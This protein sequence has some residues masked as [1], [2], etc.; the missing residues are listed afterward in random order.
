MVICE[1]LVEDDIFVGVLGLAGL[2]ATA[3]LTSELYAEDPIELMARN[4]NVYIL[5]G[6][7]ESV[8]SVTV[9]VKEGEVYELSFENTDPSVP[10]F[11]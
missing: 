8:E 11:I 10:V 5:P 6:K 4:L 3:Y 9:W 2:L 1:V 7:R